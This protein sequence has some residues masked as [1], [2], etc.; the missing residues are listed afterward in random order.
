[1]PAESRKM[2]N[3]DRTVSEGL[4]ERITLLTSLHGAGEHCPVGSAAAD[5]LLDDHIQ[6]VINPLRL[7][8]GTFLTDVRDLLDN[9]AGQS[10]PLEIQILRD[11]YESIPGEDLLRRYDQLAYIEPPFEPF[12]VPA[13]DPSLEVLVEGHHKALRDAPVMLTWHHSA[14]T[15]GCTVEGAILTSSDEDAQAAIISQSSPGV[16]LQVVA[17]G[18]GGAQLGVGFLTMSPE[19]VLQAAHIANDGQLLPAL[20][21]GFSAPPYFT[22][23]VQGHASFMWTPSQLHAGNVI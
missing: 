17:C 8:L 13:Q 22:D 1:M 7:V 14:R 16:R 3:V 19:Q 4:M 2:M 15:Q 5:K 6:R 10:S 11:H 12:D 21:P 18:E 23:I 20:G 9:T